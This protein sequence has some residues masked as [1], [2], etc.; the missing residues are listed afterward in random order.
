MSNAN[1]TEIGSDN[2]TS[3][4]ALVP[5]VEEPFSGTYSDWYYRDPRTDTSGVFTFY[6]MTR[7]LYDAWERSKWVGSKFSLADVNT[8]GVYCDQELYE[9]GS[10]D[11]YTIVIDTDMELYRDLCEKHLDRLNHKLN[12]PDFVL[13]PD[14][15]PSDRPDI[16]VECDNCRRTILLSDVVYKDPEFVDAG[17][18]ESVRTAVHDGRYCSDLCAGNYVECECG[19]K[20]TSK[21]GYAGHKAHCG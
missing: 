19:R 4:I 15:T 20:F 16:A 14:L 1:G 9:D 6:T 21:Q 3:N 2:D 13:R 5:S 8:P 12:G 18:M 11:C 17:P 7:A 10:P